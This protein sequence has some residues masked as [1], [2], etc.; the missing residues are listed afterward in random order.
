ML[1]GLR[2]QRSANC[3]VVRFWADTE[4]LAKI[5]D[6]LKRQADKLA[7]PRLSDLLVRKAEAGE[8]LSR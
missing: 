3:S 5:V 2:P 4:G 8:K 1:D 7:D 6:G